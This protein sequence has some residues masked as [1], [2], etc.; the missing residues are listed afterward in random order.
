MSLPRIQTV[1][2]CTTQTTKKYESRIYNLCPRRVNFIPAGFF[3]RR[4]YLIAFAL[5]LDFCIRIGQVIAYLQFRCSDFHTL[6]QF[7]PDVESQTN[8]TQFD[9]GPTRML[10]HMRRDR[11]LTHGSSRKSPGT[12]HLAFCALAFHSPLR[13]Y[14]TPRAPSHFCI[15]AEIGH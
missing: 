9:E 15:V 11:S 3:S 10:F 6:K 14:N 12:F 2:L 7:S 8:Q 13:K 5:E 1:A 4:Y